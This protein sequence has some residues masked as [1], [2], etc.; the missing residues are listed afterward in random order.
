[1][2]KNNEKLKTRE[3]PYIL[4]RGRYR[5]NRSVSILAREGRWMQ[6]W[7]CEEGMDVDLNKKGVEDSVTFYITRNSHWSLPLCCQRT[8][9]SNSPNIIPHSI[10]NQFHTNSAV[11]LCYPLL[12]CKKL[13]KLL[14]R[15]LKLI[16]N[17]PLKNN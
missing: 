7:S 3:I 6:N 13:K 11:E 14:H 10:G 8:F 2:N 4:A 15:I 1:M 9:L 5:S 12:Y 17:D 16:I